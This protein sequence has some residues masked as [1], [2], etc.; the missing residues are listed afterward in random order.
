MT[1][2][3]TRCQA[4]DQFG[5]RCHLDAGHDLAGAR[6][7]ALTATTR[8]QRFTRWATTDPYA[9]STRYRQPD[10]RTSIYVPV[11]NLWEQAS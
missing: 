5:T 3:L 2:E 9:E 11:P 1:D 8:W 10:R 4:R 6:H 7:A